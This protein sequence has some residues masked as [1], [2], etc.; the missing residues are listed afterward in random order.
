MF[1]SSVSVNFYLFCDLQAL[2]RLTNRE[3]VMEMVDPALQGQYSKKDLVQVSLASI[4]I[5]ITIIDSKILLT[6]FLPFDVV[7]SRYCSCVC[8]TRSRLS[9]SND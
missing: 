9:A 8:A 3:K 7:D 2:P 4:V 1:K 6:L 5:I